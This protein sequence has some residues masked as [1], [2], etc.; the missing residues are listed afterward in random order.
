VVIFHKKRP[1]ISWRSQVYTAKAH[2]VQG[3]TTPER[4]DRAKKLYQ[5]FCGG[6]K[7]FFA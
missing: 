7:D 6:V 5:V 4:R 1:C 3:L 2:Q